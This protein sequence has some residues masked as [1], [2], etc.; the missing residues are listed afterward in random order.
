[1]ANVWISDAS[2][3]LLE[4][5]RRMLG[6]II[7][8]TPEGQKELAS[9]GKLTLCN[10][11][12]QH[13]SEQFERVTLPRKW[14]IESEIPQDTQGKRSQALIAQRFSIHD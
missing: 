14:R 2:V 4:G 8:L 5:T 12:K 10:Q 3:V 6:A 13:L 11:I 9:L 1:M 7:V